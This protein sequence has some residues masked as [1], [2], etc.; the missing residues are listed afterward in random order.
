MTELR[1]FDRPG[2]RLFG[3]PPGAD[4]PAELLRGLEG[5][6][7]DAPPHA[8]ARVQI[9]V[10]TRRMAR[11]LRRLYDSGPARLLPRIDLLTGLDCRAAIPPSVSSIRRRLELIRLISALLDAEPDLA[12]RAALYDLADSLARLLDEMQG[13]RVRWTT[14]PRWTYRTCR[15]TGRGH[16]VSWKSSGRSRAATT[17]RTPR[18]VSAAWSRR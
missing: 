5:R 6:L 3:L 1:L 17:C 9:V 8:R 10:N 16:S 18:N 12:P 7:G 14:S 4:F 13:E 11:R 15:A 2:P